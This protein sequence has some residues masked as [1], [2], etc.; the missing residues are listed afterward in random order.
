MDKS[1]EEFEMAEDDNHGS[2]LG[3]ILSQL[4]IGMDLTKV[5]LP[6]FIL[7][8]KSF[9]EKMAD[10]MVHPQFLLRGMA[11]DCNL[12][13]FISVVQWYLSAFHIRP[14]GVKK[15]Y[16]PILGEHF[17][18]WTDHQDGSTTVLTAE[19]V[20][21]HPP[22]SCFHFENREAGFV[23]DAFMEPKS[24]YL[25]NSAAS[26]LHGNGTLYDIN[27]G[28]EYKFNFPTAYARGILVGKLNMEIGEKVRIECVETELCIEIDFKVKGLI[29]GEANALGGKLKKGTLKSGITTHRLKGHWDKKIY[30]ENIETKEVAEIFDAQTEP[31][32]KMTIPHT[33]VQDEF[34]SRRLWK[35]VSQSLCERPPN[36][37]RA[38]NEKTKL[39][40]AQRLSAKQRLELNK[41]WKPVFFKKI[42]S[43]SQSGKEKKKKEKSFI[44]E[45]QFGQLKTD[46]FDKEKEEVHLN[47]EKDK[48]LQRI[49]QA[50]NLLSHD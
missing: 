12:D 10:F 14:K 16:N 3:S 35:E 33:V 22:I 19:Q 24:K 38:T 44:D 31:V 18:A 39:E 11:K 48:R 36:Q 47:S 17:H 45:W 1:I 40:D 49:N 5:V 20:S 25:G 7:E 8:P 28:H 41:E 42:E 27:R 9:L 30:L 4:R 29:W 34:E 2:L 32:V 15:P 43:N 37:K 26:I 23:V 46:P 21:H 50:V 6:T 13:R